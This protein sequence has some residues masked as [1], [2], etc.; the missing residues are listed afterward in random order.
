MLGLNQMWAG[1]QFFAQLPGYL[2]RPISLEKAH[3]SLAERLRR[4]DERFLE[5]VRLD[6]YERPASPYF[7]L[8][9]HAGCELGDVESGVR[10]DGLDETLRRLF[11]AGVYLTSDEFKGRKT[12]RRGSWEVV[13]EPAM[14]QAPRASY[15]VPASSGGSRS[16]GTPVMIDLEFIR[17]CAANAAV[18]MAARGGRSWR[19][20]VWESPGA[21][22]RFRTIKYAGFGEPPAAAFTQIDTDSA[23]IPPYFR[24]NLRLMYWGG[25]VARRPL[26]WPVYAPFSDP[27]PLADWLRRTRAAGHTPHLQT[28]PGSAVILARWAVENGYDIS[29]TWL[30]VSGEPITQA[31]LATMRAA[32]CN[33]IPRYGTMEVGAIGY[34]C[35]NGQHSDDLHL[36]TDMHGMIHAGLDGDAIG[37][38]PK[39]LLM[40]SLHPQAPFVMLNLSMGDQADLGKCDCDCPLREA[41]WHRRIWNVR[42]YEKL[43]GT[44][45]NFD[46]AQVIPIL[47]ETLP[48]NFGGAPT[49]YQLAEAEG[50][51]G[52]PLL[53]LIVHPRLG[54]LDERAIAG[55]F[56][57]ALGSKSTSD[58]M[59]ARRLRDAGTLIVE[60]REPAMTKSGKIN[61]LHV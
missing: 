27:S 2:R 6:I 42:S 57:S 31:R 23:D 45:V 32:G 51:N 48:S 15:H 24:W 47:E 56:L 16:K 29:G 9:H 35:P 17:T 38:P 44:G 19:K 53:K 60:R 55:K 40:T 61:Y 58:A 13:V 5:K 59:M 33:V 25:Q 26:P 11:R 43:S 28:F 37:L 12:A 21:G 1:A 8:L 36:L 41:G 30:T 54:D 50:P 46:A 18:S 39:A 4:R 3:T 10:N 20:A 34:G 7:Q 49:D 14:L 52:E 22:L